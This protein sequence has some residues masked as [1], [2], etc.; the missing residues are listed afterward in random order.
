MM[1]MSSPP[2]SN[3][4]TPLPMGVRLDSNKFAG[5]IVLEGLGYFQLA[6]ATE[7]NNFRRL[8]LT[9][10]FGYWLLAGFLVSH[11]MDRFYSANMSKRIRKQHGLA[12]LK[13]KA[14]RQHSLIHLPFELLEQSQSL[15]KD[16]KG[17]WTPRGRELIKQASHQ[18]QIQEPELERLLNNS[19]FRRQLNYAKAGVSFL[20]LAILAIKGQTYP[21]LSNWLTE[22]LS[23]KKGFSGTFNYTTNEYRSQEAQEY[24]KNKKRNQLISAG[25]G[26]GAALSVPF[27]LLT[28]LEGKGN[29]SKK[30]K[31]FLPNLNYAEAVYMPKPI[32]FVH[33]LFN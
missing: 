1:M 24:E 2:L 13:G 30:M 26:F 5:R 9:F 33:T 32:F 22:T 21:W 28:A 4:F 15:V 3:S 14:A 17:A 8:E 18:L 6:L 20:D 12:D 31:S 27:L 19:K 25:L 16:A 10:D 29:L 23:K 7:R 11:C